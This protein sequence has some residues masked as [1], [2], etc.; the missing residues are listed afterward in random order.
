MT[1]ENATATATSTLTPLRDLYKMAARANGS[2][3]Q[4]LDLDKLTDADILAEAEHF[5]RAKAAR[6]GKWNP[7]TGKPVTAYGQ[8]RGG[9]TGG[10]VRGDGIAVT[11]FGE[12][13]QRQSDA[14]GGIANLLRNWGGGRRGGFGVAIAPRP[15]TP[16]AAPV[17]EMSSGSLEER[18]K[19]IRAAEAEV[20]A[21]MTAVQER[22]AAALN[23]LLDEVAEFSDL[24]RD[25]LKSVIEEAKATDLK[26]AMRAVKAFSA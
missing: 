12:N 20:V 24:D 22:E 6:S 21:A 19:A 2:M 15:V 1:T 18:L 16:T 3:I 17:K 13:L 8:L 10:L 7:T 14:A 9:A 23:E 25:T 4:C 26:S 5:E 11:M